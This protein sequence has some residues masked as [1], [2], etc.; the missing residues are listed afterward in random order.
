LL[1]WIEIIRP[2]WF[3]LPRLYPIVNALRSLL[4][5]KIIL[6]RSNCFH[7]GNSYVSCNNPFTFKKCFYHQ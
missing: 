3:V 7:F 5:Y 4:R 1:C 2:R 6:H